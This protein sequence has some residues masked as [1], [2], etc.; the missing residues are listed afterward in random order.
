MQSL[1]CLLYAL[2]FFRSPYDEVYERGDSVALAVSSG[3]PLHFPSPTTFPF[4]VHPSIIELITNMLVV[5][6]TRRP[7]IG[8]IIRQVESIRC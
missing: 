6:P 4:N 3:T 5:D 8:D 1:G 7:F 2:C